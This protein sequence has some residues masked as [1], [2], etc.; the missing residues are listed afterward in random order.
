MMEKDQWL[1]GEERAQKQ[2]EK[3]EAR[4]AAE[5][6]YT[7]KTALFRSVFGSE[8]GRQ[9]LVSLLDELHLFS[10]CRTDED[11]ALREFGIHFL[12]TRLGVADL[13]FIT[14]VVVDLLTCETTGAKGV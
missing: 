13:G 14:K 11:R 8:K 5:A 6:A 12:R 9:E 2:K 4:A 7:Q 10:E 3:E 1:T